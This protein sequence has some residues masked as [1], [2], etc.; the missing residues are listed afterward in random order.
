MSSKCPK[1]QQLVT[2]L[3][4]QGLEAVGPNRKTWKAATFTCP[5]CDTILGASF[6]AVAQ[7]QWVIDEVVKKLRG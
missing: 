5:S 1:C 6:D 4:V 2:S 3:R 7:G